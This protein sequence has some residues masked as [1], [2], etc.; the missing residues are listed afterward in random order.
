[1]ESVAGMGLALKHPLTALRTT[2]PVVDKVTPTT[3]PKVLPTAP[4]R[5]RKLALA[6]VIVVVLGV[7]GFVSWRAFLSPVTVSV[8]PVQSNVRAQV[9]GLGTIGARVQSNVGFKVAGVLF[10]LKADQGDRAKAGQVLAQLDARD[11]EAQLALAKAGVAQARANID[12]AKADVVSATA[13]LANTKAIAARRA[14]LVKNGYATVEETQTADAA[15]RVAGANLG[16][17]QSLVTVAEAALQSAEA[18]EA[19]EEATLANYTLYAP[20]D[21][22]VVSRNLELGSATNPGQSVYTLVAAH[23]VWALGYVDE[24]LAGRL[25]VGQPAEIILRSNP[26][27]PIPGHVERV[28]IQ[29][30]AVNEERLVDVAFDQ[31]PDNIHLA[32][33]AEVIITV[34]VLPRAILVQPSAVTDFRGDRGAGGNGAVWTVE[35]GRIER[36]QVTFGPELLDGRLPIL[37][38]LPANCAVVA[39]P[40]SGLR[41]GRAARIAEVPTS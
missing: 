41:V 22:W 3:P 11:I 7:A 23:T 12:K 17:A 14:A 6:A 34:G 29:S 26:A 40:V 31:V 20:Y 24:R 5:G 18:Q 39:A 1:M 35:Q 2:T 21:A 13:N 19:F 8:A 37:E 9:F 33:Q 27:T 4:R 32:E 10:A 15:A 25:S 28:E 30:D 16:A 38:G 36:R